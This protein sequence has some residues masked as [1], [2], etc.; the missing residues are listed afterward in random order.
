MPFG[1]ASR[2]VLLENIAVIE[3]AVVVKMLVDRGGGEQLTLL[4]RET[5]RI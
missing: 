1:E 5:K 3:V 4:V 2:T